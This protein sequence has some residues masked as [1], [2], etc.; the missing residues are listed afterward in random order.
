M[1]TPIQTKLVKLDLLTKEERTWLNEY[2]DEVLSKVGPLLK[3][4][5][6]ALEWLQTECRHV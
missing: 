4:D 3:K 5:K 6:L 2:H 1:K